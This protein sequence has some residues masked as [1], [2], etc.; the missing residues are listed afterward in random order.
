M[1]PAP[2]SDLGRVTIGPDD[3]TPPMGTRLPPTQRVPRPE[4]TRLRLKLDDVMGRLHAKLDGINGDSAGKIA[5]QLNPKATRLAR[6]AFS[7][8]ELELEETEDDD[9]A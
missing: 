5:Q 4:T 1:K 9:A 6:A 7:P 8:A 3:P 2:P